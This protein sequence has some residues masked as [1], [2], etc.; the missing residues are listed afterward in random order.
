MR[1][2]QI[3]GLACLLVSASGASA[4]PVPGGPSLLG[5]AADG[6]IPPPPAGSPPAVGVPPP[7][8]GAGVLP[9]LEPGEG[10]PFV[11]N[12]LF[13]A[14][15]A[16][17]TLDVPQYELPAAR[18]RAMITYLKIRMGMEKTPTQGELYAIQRMFPNELIRLCEELRQRTAANVGKVADLAQFGVQ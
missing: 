17:E 12:R 11:M 16:A 10:A 2:V 8:R 13:A 14:I 9:P 15:L 1:I 7:P 18:R 4:Q 3:L 5:V 6:V